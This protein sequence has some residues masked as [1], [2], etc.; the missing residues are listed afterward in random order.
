MGKISIALAIIGSSQAWP[1]DLP[2]LI[3]D[4][5]AMVADVVDAGADLVEGAVDLGV[6][7]GTGAVDLGLDIL[8]ALMGDVDLHLTVD[9]VPVAE[10][11]PL[12]PMPSAAGS[13]SSSSSG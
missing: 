7:I 2:V 8:D 4:P 13:S 9:A 10:D 6:D 5:F 12:P 3:P 1:W 11:E